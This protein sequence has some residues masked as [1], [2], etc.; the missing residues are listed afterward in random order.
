MKDDFGLPKFESGGPEMDGPQSHSQGRAFPSFAATHYMIGLPDL[1]CC[2]GKVFDPSRIES[3][4]V[5]MAGNH[6]PCT[7]L[8]SQPGGFSGIE[9]A[10]NP[11]VGATAV[12][13]QECHIDFESLEI[14]G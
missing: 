7:N 3:E 9:V 11:P 5:V 4:H 14:F 1:T 12:N 6:E 10:G 13:R 8:V 2:F